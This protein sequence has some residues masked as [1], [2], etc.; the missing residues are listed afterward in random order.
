MVEPPAGGPCEPPVVPRPP[1][2]PTSAWL[3]ARTYGLC[4]IPDAD[5]R[6]AAHQVPSRVRT[7]LQEV[8]VSELPVVDLQRRAREEET[9]HM[10]HPGLRESLRQ[11]VAPESAPEVALRGAAVCV[12][13]ALLWQELHQVGRAAET[14]EDSH[15]GEALRVP[16]LLQEVHAER[17]LGKARENAPE[18][19]EQMPRKDVGPRPPCETGRPQEYVVTRRVEVH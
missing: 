15:G 6:V 14:P 9:A 18:Q 7:A 4:A 2:V 5:R 13:L 16:G 8:Q 17:S 10:S 12:Q 11:D 19:K 1:S 3:G